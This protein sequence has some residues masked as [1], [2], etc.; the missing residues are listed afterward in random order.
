MIMSIRK[1]HKSNNYS[2]IY[3]II[4]PNRV[5][6]Q[7]KIHYIYV[8]SITFLSLHAYEDPVLY[9]LHWIVTCRS[10]AMIIN[11]LNLLCNLSTPDC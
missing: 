8:Y 1:K 2:C 4:L 9:I 7:G 11:L 6:F 3:Y 10:N 5:H